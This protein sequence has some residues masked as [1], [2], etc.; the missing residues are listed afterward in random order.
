[1]EV[2]YLLHIM[3]NNLLLTLA[4]IGCN[5]SIAG[6]PDGSVMPD[7]AL[8]SDARAANDVGTG[9]DV[10]PSG[11]DATAADAR[12]P[13]DAWPAMDVASPGPD[14]SPIEDASEP[15]PDASSVGL[16]A[17]SGAD[18]AATC[19][20]PGNLSRGRAWTRANPLFVSALTVAMGPPPSSAVDDYS[21][22]FHAS[23]VHTWADGLATAIPGWAAAGRPDFRYV[24][25]VQADGTCTSNGLLLGGAAPLPGR[26]GYQIGDE[27][28]DLAGVQA[29]AAGAAAV[30]SADPQALIIL[31]LTLDIADADNVLAQAAELAD[32]DVLSIDFYN[33][34]KAA[35][36]K[37]GKLRAAALANNKAWWRYADGFHYT[38]ETDPATEADLRWDAY[39]GPVY[40][41]TGHTWFIYQI[42]PSN[43]DLR[44]LFFEQV[45][46]FSSP[47]TTQFGWAAKL[48][49]EL[50]SLGR[51]LSLLRSVEVR[52]APGIPL[53]LPSGTTAWAAGA[54][55]EPYLKTIAATG[56]VRDAV[57]G[58]FRDDCDEPYV[59]IQNVAHPGADFPNQ[60]AQPGGF[61]LGFDFSK[62]TDPSLDTSAVLVLDPTTGQVASRSLSSGSL[63]LT[64]PAGGAV[65]FKYQNARPFVS[66]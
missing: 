41:F 11:V 8:A 53:V 59:M 39:L 36:E 21:D 60:S 65:L 24:S 22:A 52:Y 38:T 54:G 12:L 63:D 66:Q 13:P 58:L 62:S 34:K 45:G 23:A 32:V 43:P 47:R 55:G 64:I 51:S 29:M 7:A 30:R 17:A 28:A 14:A 25:W 50:A 3:R 31:N 35:Y 1:M 33:Y 46:D 57:V 61:K 26:I 48:N 4:L 9:G 42:D 20:V 44:P 49:T 19:S 2:R 6:G 10:G 16:D 56:G 18:A 37:A 27:P 40:G 5:S 15:G